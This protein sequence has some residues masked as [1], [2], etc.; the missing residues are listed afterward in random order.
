[1][2]TVK[3]QEITQN[4]RPRNIP[5]RKVTIEFWEKLKASPVGA[6]RWKLVP[7]KTKIETKE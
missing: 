5:P 2:K 3:I 4:G 1:M 7:E 6:K